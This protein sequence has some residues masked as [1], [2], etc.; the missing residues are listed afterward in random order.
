MT[1][2]NTKTHPPSTLL[3][4]SAEARRAALRLVG[5][6]SERRRELFEIVLA[7]AKRAPEWRRTLTGVEALRWEVDLLQYGKAVNVLTAC[8]F[9]DATVAEIAAGIA[10][11]CGRFSFEPNQQRRRAYQRAAKVRT[12]NAER[13]QAILSEHAAGVSQ[14]VIAAGHSVSRGCVEKVIR[15][16][17]KPPNTTPNPTAKKPPDRLLCRLRN[18]DSEGSVSEILCARSDTAG[19]AG[20]RLRPASQYRAAAS[21]LAAPLTHRMRSDPEPEPAQKVG[22]Q[23]QVDVTEQLSKRRL[24]R[25]IDSV[26]DPDPGP[27]QGDAERAERME[28]QRAHDD[29]AWRAALPA[30]PR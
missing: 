14:R 4:V 2:V 22:Q 27:I 8:P 23:G 5:P 13:N 7:R 12:R 17:K 18:P 3:E 10:R 26:T 6:D 1:Q 25:A 15:A 16:A 28:A 30:L 20:A 24:M 9:Q 11:R 29:A 21:L 19:G